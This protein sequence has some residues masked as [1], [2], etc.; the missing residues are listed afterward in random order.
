MKAALYA[1]V[2]NRIE[3]GNPNPTARIQQNIRSV[4]GISL[5]GLLD[6][7]RPDGDPDFVRRGRLRLRNVIGK[8]HLLKERLSRRNN[9]VC[10]S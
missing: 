4:L 6:N 7:S 2:T 10:V 1:G 3:R 5:W 8:T 9:R